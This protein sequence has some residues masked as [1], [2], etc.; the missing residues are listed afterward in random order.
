MEGFRTQ[1]VS[2][3]LLTIEGETVTR[4]TITFPSEAEV[5][6]QIPRHTTQT[7]PPV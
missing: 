4:I 3:A 7:A 1:S 2:G 5:L 6:A